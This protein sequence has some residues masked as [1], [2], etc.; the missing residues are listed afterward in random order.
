MICSSPGKF[1]LPCNY[2]F[3]MVIT[4]L[5][6]LH[7]PFRRAILGSPGFF[8]R[9]ARTKCGFTNAIGLLGE[10]IA[11]QEGKKSGHP[12]QKQT[13]QTNIV[14]FLFIISNPHNTLT[15]LFQYWLPLHVQEVHMIWWHV[16]ILSNFYQIVQIIKKALVT[17]TM[18]DLK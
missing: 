3:F 2:S 14:S 4:R 18:L 8:K 10:G 1:S 15:F 12:H 9:Q 7:K 13:K 11:S 6:A 17:F 16:I 5:T